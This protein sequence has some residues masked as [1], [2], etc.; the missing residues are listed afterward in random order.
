VSDRASLRLSESA[1]SLAIAGAL[2]DAFEVLWNAD[3]DAPERDS[4]RAELQAFCGNEGAALAVAKTLSA[5]PAL[6]RIRAAVAVARGDWA[7]CVRRTDGSCEDFGAAVLRARALVELD[8][9]P[10]AEALLALA[11]GAQA[12]PAWMS[13][14]LR[15]RCNERAATRLREIAH[16]AREEGAALAEAE[17]WTE[18]FEH[19]QRGGDDQAAAHAASRAVE[20]WEELAITLPPPLRSGFWL[21]VRRAAVRAAS[22]RSSE[23]ETPEVPQGL[24]TLLHTVGRLASER[25]REKLLG[26]ITDGAVAL[27]EAERGFVLLVDEFG[28]LEPTTVRVAESLLGAP[29]A[30]FSRSI[31]ETVLI[32]GEPV[33]TVD[34]TQDAR[35]QDYMSV[36]QLMLKSV[37]CL[38]IET[39]GRTWGVLYLEHRSSCGRFAGA[40]LALL[41]AFADQAAIAIETSEL[42]TRVEAQKRALERANQALLEANSQLEAKLEGQS[43]A[44]ERTRLEIT[45]LRGSEDARGRW[46]LVG[47]SDGMQRLYDMID[48]VAANDIPVVVTGESGTGKELVARAIHQASARADGAFVSVSCGAIPDGLL[49]SELFGHVA[50]AFTGATRARD[51]VFIEASGGTLFLDEIADMPARMQLDLLRVLQESRVRPVGASDEKPVD[52]RVVAASKRPLQ[53]LVDE[54][55]LRED[56]YYRLSVVEIRV[57]P[58]RDRRADLPILCDHILAKLAGERGE[59]KKRIHAQALQRLAMH[60]FPGNVRELEHVLISATVFAAGDSIEAKD[61]ALAGEVA[62]QP[63]SPAT[64]S[65]RDYKQVERDRIL[66]ALNAHGWNRA[67]AARA[68]GIPRRTFYRR[69]KQHDIELPENS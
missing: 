48:R 62:V 52:V 12:F 6:A 32:D 58:L 50:G 28:K 13:R 57:P 66:H 27:S 4:T 10:E 69:L 39:R 7:D 38:P 56:L 53:S 22:S 18:L 37:A 20:R 42:I 5:G 25:D 29:T 65:Y 45:R 3:P 64:E 63:A 31:A 34:A 43:E 11:S 59:P 26:A 44:L 68:L 16:E 1:W 36:H 41:R 47:R 40:D 30:A 14:I 8:R 49:E 60:E 55:T 35:V 15:A 19:H 61:L 46:G 9:W 17:A 33:V 24:G 21:P 67:R 51:G 2:G 54:G 23:R